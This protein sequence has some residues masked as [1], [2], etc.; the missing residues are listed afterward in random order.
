MEGDYCYSQTGVHSSLADI[1]QHQPCRI[2]KELLP[3]ERR[4][5]TKDQTDVFYSYF[6]PLTEQRVRSSAIYQVHWLNK[7]LQH[8]QKSDVHGHHTYLMAYQL[9]PHHMSW[10]ERSQITILR[11]AAREPTARCHY[12]VTGARLPPNRAL[13]EG[14]L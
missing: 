4:Q 13:C 6:D 11:I 10:P 12:D 2:V 3:E 7:A 8:V 5:I 1:F 9:L 14:C